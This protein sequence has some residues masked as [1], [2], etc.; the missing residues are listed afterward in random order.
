MSYQLLLVLMF[1]LVKTTLLS[2]FAPCQLK[3]WP[4]LVTSR[5]S[6]VDVLLVRT[7]L[8]PDGNVPSTK[9]LVFTVPEP[10]V[11]NGISPWPRPTAEILMT[12]FVPLVRLPA[13]L[14]AATVGLLLNVP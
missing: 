10:T 8:T 5:S 13:P 7:P 9:P 2:E 11:I 6:E 4:A 3:S 1:Q 12:T 14:R